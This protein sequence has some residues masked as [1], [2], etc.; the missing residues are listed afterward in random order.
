MAGRFGLS[1]WAGSLSKSGVVTG[2]IGGLM[3]AMLPVH[4]L[5]IISVALSAARAR[6]WPG[7]GFVTAFAAGLAAGLATLAFG[8]GETSAADVLLAVVLLSGVAT[9][10]AVT[11]PRRVVES[12]AFV[13]GYGLGLD[14]PPDAIL[15]RDAILSLV[16]TWCAGVTLLAAVFAAATPLARPA[17]GIALRVAGSWIA[18]TAILVLG[19]RWA[20]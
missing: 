5:A 19:L 11:V 16:G 4:V 9:V 15:L 10:A 6:L 1:P 12:A 18:A 13:V 14:S 2:L 20:A 7:F 8:A 3:Q 17:N